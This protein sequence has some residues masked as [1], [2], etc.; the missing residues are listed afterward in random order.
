VADEALIAFNDGD[1]PF[2]FY[3]RSHGFLLY[4]LPAWEPS[5][6]IGYASLLFAL[7]WHTH[8]I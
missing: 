6:N 4:A 3:E 1:G 5:R 2:V 8:V 7:P